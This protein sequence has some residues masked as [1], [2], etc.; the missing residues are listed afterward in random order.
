MSTEINVSE[1]Y[2]VSITT[3]S[4][5][6]QAKTQF[7]WLFLDHFKFPSFHSFPGGWPPC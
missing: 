3:H 7:P 1:A 2:F 5:T 6:S 4:N